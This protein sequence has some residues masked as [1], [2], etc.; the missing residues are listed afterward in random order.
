MAG[1]PTYCKD[2]INLLNTITVRYDYLKDKTGKLAF[3]L[4]KGAVIVPNASCINVMTI[5]NGTTPTVTL[6]SLAQPQA[7]ATSTDVTPATQ[8]VRPVLAATINAG[9]LWSPAVADTDIFFTVTTT[10]T[11]QGVVLITVSFSY[12][13]LLT[14]LL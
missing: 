6:G 1:V 5:F 9:A 2:K 13:A 4:P 7:I 8:G 14:D 3:T 10:N 11:T 12:P